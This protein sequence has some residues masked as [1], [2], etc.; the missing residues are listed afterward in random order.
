M[1]A[2]SNLTTNATTLYRVTDFLIEAPGLT[3]SQKFRSVRMYFCRCSW[4]V[5]SL[6]SSW[7]I[8]TALFGF[9]LGLL[10]AVARFYGVKP[11]L[12]ASHL[13]VISF[14]GFPLL[15]LLFILYLGLPSIVIILGSFLSALFGFILC[16]SAYNSEYIRCALKSVKG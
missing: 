7:V 3:F 2:T 16:N 8:L 13:Y 12:W 15:L 9:L 6:R 10:V 14:L 1:D 5:L 4:T 11:V